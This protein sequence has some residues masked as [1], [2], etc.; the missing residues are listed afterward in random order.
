[1]AIA[2]QPLFYGFYL[3]S[4]GGLWKQEKTKWVSVGMVLAIFINIVLAVLL[5][6]AYQLIGA[7]AA[8]AVAFLVWNIFTVIISERLWP[9]HYPF[10]VF[11]LQ[12]GAGVL[13]VTSILL[14]YAQSQEIWKVVLVALL[15][16]GLISGITVE[17]SHIK[18]LLQKIGS[19]KSYL[20]EAISAFTSKIEV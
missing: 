17:R 13:A 1:M 8:T 6:P 15:S 4:S 3:I 7:A 14:L 9:V 10:G 18:W 2:W 16:S 19:D 11:G 20:L 5:V 12:I